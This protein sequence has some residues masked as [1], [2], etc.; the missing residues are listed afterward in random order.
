MNC[1][2]FSN[3]VCKLYNRFWQLAVQ[4]FQIFSFFYLVWWKLTVYISK[5]ILVFPLGAYCCFWFFSNYNVFFFLILF[6]FQTPH[7]CISSAKH[8]NESIT[9]TRWV[10]LMFLRSSAFSQIETYVHGEIYLFRHT[11]SYWNFSLLITLGAISSFS[12]FS[13]YYFLSS[14]SFLF[15]SHFIF[16]FSCS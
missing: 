4:D 12:S 10:F 6:Y 2:F 15:T 7:N 16:L 3:L 8:Q 5:W 1:V 13:L 9:G 11:M 14:F